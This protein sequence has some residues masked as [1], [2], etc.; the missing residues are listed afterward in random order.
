[1]TL[2]TLKKEFAFTVYFLNSK[3]ANDRWD[4]SKD[5]TSKLMWYELNFRQNSWKI[6]MFDLIKIQELEA[7]EPKWVNPVLN[8]IG[9][10]LL[11]LGAIQLTD[12]FVVVSLLNSCIIIFRDINSKTMASPYVG[13]AIMLMLKL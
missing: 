11:R 10:N 4:G 5:K 13:P 2:K 8:I 12:T 6:A 3:N 7:S 9:V 1:M